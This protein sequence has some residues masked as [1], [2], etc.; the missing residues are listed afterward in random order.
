MKTTVLP[1]QTLFDIALQTQG[2]A[3]YAL[4]IADGNALPLSAD[5][6]PGTKLET[7]V[8]AQNSVTAAL[9]AAPPATALDDGDIH[10]TGINFMTI[11]DESRLTGF[12][13]R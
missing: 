5:P 10:F 7:G 12:W 4:L 3:D 1:N 2:N 6:E 8:T 13:V 9:A 11:E